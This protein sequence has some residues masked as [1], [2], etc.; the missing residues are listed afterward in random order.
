[1]SVRFSSVLLISLTAGLYSGCSDKN[2]G[3]D[4][5][6]VDHS[7]SDTDTDSDT[8]SGTDSDTGSDTDSDT[9]SEVDSGSVTD[10]GYDADLS[11]DSD[12][13]GVDAGLDCD[14]LD[15][16]LGSVLED[17]DCDGFIG[18][19]DCDDD[20]SDVNI[21]AVESCATVYDDDCDGVLNQ[22]DA[23]GCTAYF[24]DNDFDGFGEG[25]SKCFCSP[26]GSF[27]S[28]VATDCDDSS[29]SYSPVETE[30]CD[31]GDHD[32]DGERFDADDCLAVG[33]ISQGSDSDQTAYVSFL[34]TV[35][36][37]FGET[38][39]V[40]EDMTTLAEYSVLLA[41]P[42]GGITN[43]RWETYESGLSSSGVPILGMYNAGYWLFGHMDKEYGYPHGATSTSA[44]TGT[45]WLSN[46]STESFWGT[47]S[48]GVLVDSTGDIF[49]DAYTSV[50]GTTSKIIFL[51]EKSSRESLPVFL[52]G[53]TF[54]VLSLQNQGSDTRF[55][56]NL[57]NDGIYS[58]WA[59]NG[60]PSDWTSSGETVFLESLKYI[61]E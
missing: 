4:E 55:Y 34:N 15:A 26:A 8:G 56:A 37:F 3:D 40:D 28:L 45:F 21:G 49:V 57:I 2:D 14:D 10:T 12:G 51:G 24:E 47:W 16:S 41:T 33:V 36:G 30:Q 32:C 43:T 39:N 38:I 5:V 9:G 61:A 29:A 20:N 19:D 50:S 46:T 6:V 35:D 59:M 7:E 11:V 48:D 13:D 31:S 54:D 58:Y 25:E 60:T 22:E 1:M 27:T 17:G 44:V 18:I 52:A 42:N 53:M 23:T